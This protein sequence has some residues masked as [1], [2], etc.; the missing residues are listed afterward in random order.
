LGHPRGR[1]GIATYRD[2]FLIYNPSAR[3]LEGRRIKRVD[4]ALEALHQA[5]HRVLAIRTQGRGTASGIA[6]ECVRGGAGLI[7]VAGGDGT[8]NEVANGM[9]HAAIPLGILPAGTGNVLATELDL[10]GHVDEVAREVGAWVPRR[11]SAGLLTASGGA[12]QRHFL[13]MA[14]VGFD[15]H[16]VSRVD[17]NLKKSHGKL[18]YW[19]AGAGE[20]KSRLDEF[21]VTVGATRRRAT[22]ALAGRVRN[23]GGTVK[24]TRHAGLLRADF[25]LILFEGRNTFR[26]LK[27]LAGALTNR[28]ER[29]H[30]VSV[31]HVEAA[32]F[33]VSGEK[34]VYVEVDGEIAGKL[35]AK[36]E[37][38]PDALTLL[39]PPGFAG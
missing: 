5:G 37:I 23:Y 1:A 26:Y 22:F 7:L 36:I 27:Y 10:R 14:G 24:I 34:P 2:G 39:T 13:M 6:R 8:I 17:P 3:G 30:G 21:D 12:V 25:G 19:I 15:A 4:R 29:M 32:E 9:I 31:L 38:V 20:L 11:I 16:V 35:P 33:H 18:S 28:L